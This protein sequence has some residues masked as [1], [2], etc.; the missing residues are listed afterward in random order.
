MFGIARTTGTGFLKYLSIAAIGT[1]LLGA[2]ALP[3][4]TVSLVLLVAIVGALAL[5]SGGKADR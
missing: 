3:F 4:E 5:S 2:Y 1:Q